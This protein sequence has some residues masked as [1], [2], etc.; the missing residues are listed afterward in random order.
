MTSSVLRSHIQTTSTKNN[1][2][3]CMA[4]PINV[5]Q[6][7]EGICENLVIKKWALFDES[8]QHN[9]RY[10]SMRLRSPASGASTQ[11]API[12][13]DTMPA[14][15]MLA[16]VKSRRTAWELHE[17]TRGINGNLTQT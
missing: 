6:Q 9:E 15:I 4:L 12:P 8:V 7:P 11:R 17:D 1:I 3:R 16:Y 13:D 2:A 10:Y 14:Y 5:S